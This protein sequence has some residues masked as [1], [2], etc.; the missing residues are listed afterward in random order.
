MKINGINLLNENSNLTSVFA[1]SHESRI[2]QSS[3]ISID[4]V[5]LL[6]LEI[7]VV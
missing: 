2:F 1:I 3:V 7:N 5:Q 4:F 6:S